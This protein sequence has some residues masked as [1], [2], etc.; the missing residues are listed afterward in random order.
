MMRYLL[1][2]V[3]TLSVLT[4]MAQTEQFCIAKSGKTATIVVDVDDWK[5]VLMAARNPGR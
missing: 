5:G 2:I 4:G 1:T 3:M